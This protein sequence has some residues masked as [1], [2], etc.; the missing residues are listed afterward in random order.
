MFLVVAVVFII[1]IIIIISGELVLIRMQ[2]VQGC[3]LA[4]SVD[5]K[6][7]CGTRKGGKFLTQVTDYH[8]LRALL[9]FISFVIVY[10]LLLTEISSCFNMNVKISA[11]LNL[12]T[13]L[14]KS[15]N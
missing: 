7:T 10:Y 4:G 12:H 13:F 8:H 3:P 14:L 6:E 2:L 11:L 1:I 15:K 9:Y 5:K